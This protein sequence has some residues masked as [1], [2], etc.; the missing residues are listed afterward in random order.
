VKSALYFGLFQA[1]KAAGIEIPF[2]QRDLHI[3][4]GIPWEEVRKRN[5][6]GAV[7]LNPDLAKNRE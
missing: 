6:E 4:S 3:R 1:F 7:R 2:P 5:S